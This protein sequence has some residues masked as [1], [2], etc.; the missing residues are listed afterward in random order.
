M[1][2]NTTQNT[3]KISTMNINIQYRKVVIKLKQYTFYCETNDRKFNIRAFLR[4][5]KIAYEISECGNGYM[6]V[7]CATYE[8]KCKVEC[9]IANTL[10]EEIINE[11]Y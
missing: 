9:F 2:E 4:A 5:N 6:F 1:T 7:I 8:E 11:A 10:G 3:M